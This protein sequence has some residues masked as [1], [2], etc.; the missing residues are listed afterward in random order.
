MKAFVV[1]NPAAG[2]KT[3]ETVRETLAN[4]FWASDIQYEVYETIKAESVAAIV[5]AR[6]REGFDLVVA[7]GGDGTVSDVI[8][9]LMG[10]PKPLGIIPTGTGNLIARELGI[11][12]DVDGAVLVIAAAPRSRT[13]DAMTIGGR[14]FLLNAS[15]GISASVIAS[16]TRKNKHRFGRVAYLGAAVQKLFTLK[17]RHLVVTVDGLAHEYR[18]VETAVMNCGMLAKTLYPKGPEITIDDG[19]LDVWILGPKTIRDYPRYIRGVIA[20]RPLDLARFI[21]AE[22]SVSIR[23]H[24]PLPVQA[25]GDIIGTTPVVVELLR[26]AVTVLVPEV[27]APVWEVEPDREIAMA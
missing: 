11:P 7:A 26:G 10:Y 9:G 3:H 17:P 18:A 27:P 6:L 25:D 22:R 14:V 12:Q 13:I 8:D 21:I 15:V 20:G 1:L 16:T 4:R 2:K 23:S 24:V 5:H 19:H